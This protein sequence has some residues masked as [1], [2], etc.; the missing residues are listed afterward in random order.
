MALFIGRICNFS[1]TVFSRLTLGRTSKVTPPLWYEGRGGDGTPVGFSLCYDVLYKM[2]Y[3]L[4]VAAL[5]GGL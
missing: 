2:R 5:L 1:T 3:I 4:W